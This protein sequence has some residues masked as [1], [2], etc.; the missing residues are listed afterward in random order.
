MVL[1][2]V[3]LYLDEYPGTESV[4]EPLVLMVSLATG[5]LKDPVAE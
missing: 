2:P 5:E 4:A 1:A 3:A